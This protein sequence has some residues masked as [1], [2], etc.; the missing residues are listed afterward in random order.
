MFLRL[1]TNVSATNGKPTGATAGVAVRPGSNGLLPGEG[2]HDDCE[3]AVLLV[4]DRAGSGV[5]TGTFRLWG[6]VA[7]IVIGTVTITINRWF[8]IGTGADASK[9]T[10][11]AGAA[12]GETD[13]DDVGHA[14]PVVN[15][16][17]FSRLYLEVVAIGGTA[18]AFDA[19]LVSKE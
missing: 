16:R 10:I 8:P 6:F 5:M 17:M 19:V 13:T 7:S 3:D 1:L 2:F 12:L 11:N 15:L 9:G 4:W 14:E 18:T